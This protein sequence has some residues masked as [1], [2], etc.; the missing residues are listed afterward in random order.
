MMVLVGSVKGGE[1]DDTVAAYVRG[2]YVTA[3]R[4]YKPFAERG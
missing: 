4:L 3:F 2:D 1:F